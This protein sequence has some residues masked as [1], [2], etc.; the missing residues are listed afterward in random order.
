MEREECSHNGADTSIHQNS[1][2]GPHILAKMI[3]DALEKDRH[4]VNKDYIAVISHLSATEM[5]PVVMRRWLQALKLCVSQLTRDF[6]LLVG[7]TLRFSWFD[8]DPEIVQLYIDYLANLISAQTFYLKSTLTSLLQQLWIPTNPASVS[9]NIHQAMDTIL[10][11][12]P[13]APSVLMPLLTKNYPFKGR[14]PDI[15]E[16]A[17]KN[18]LYLTTY[19]PALRDGVWELIFHQMLS[20][21]VDIPRL[22]EHG[23]ISDDTDGTQFHVEVDTEPNPCY[24]KEGLN[25]EP[26]YSHV[27]VMSNE[28]A[29]KMDVMM[30]VLL[31]HLHS[32]CYND[33]VLL[34]DLA[35]H[36]L[37]LLLKIFDRMV[38]P[39]HAC[40]HV[41]FLLFRL[42]SLHESFPGIFLDF[43]WEKFQDFNTPAVL[44]QTCAAYIASYI[45]RSK[46][47]PMMMAKLCLSIM[48]R[49]IHEYL[50]GCSPDN[51][52]PEVKLHGPFFSL[53]QAVFYVF[54]FR[55]KALLDSPDGLKFSRQLNFERVISSR[56]NPLKVCLPTVVEVF[57]SITNHHEIVFCYSILEQNKRL[58]LSTP[59]V[60][61]EVKVQQQEQANLLDCYF[62]FDPYCLKSCSRS[63]ISPKTKLPSMQVI[64][65][66]E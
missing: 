28:S 20:I 14:G 39:T 11:L 62:P 35:R 22:E 8:K 37:T 24:N 10:Q 50:D 25:L 54:V 32:L 44:R 34:V 46:F 21:D 6:D 2:R 53:C 36:F 29:E 49:R 26:S 48:M 7:A 19:C 65:D 1:L 63:R 15:Q 9:C 59:V 45:A 12:V 61:P 55:H 41:Q 33:G 17:L 4:G 13:T 42:T 57:A 47:I 43:L 58:I 16:V 18:V 31:D 5:K 40:S 56:L 64:C 23:V 27:Q 66:L 51:M 38:L 30:T 3:K 52:K 60:T